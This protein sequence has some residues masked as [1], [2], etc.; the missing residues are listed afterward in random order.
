VD[1]L[2]RR[3]FWDLVHLLAHEQGV[4][5]LVSTHFM[6]EVSYADRLGF[7][8]QGRLVALGRPDEVTR[9]AEASGGPMVS[10]HAPD[11]ARAFVLVH[12][13][14]PRAMLYGRRIRWQSE[15]AE[16]DMR[17]AVTALADAG[18]AVRAE[19]QPLSMEDTFVSVL[20]AAGLGR[21]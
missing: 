17:E 18:I 8:H 1:P 13:R 7:M 6:D 14:F 5:V 15:R 10:L 12:E 4:A 19:I 2:A 3:Q 16:A 21:G 20:R 11:F 9:Q